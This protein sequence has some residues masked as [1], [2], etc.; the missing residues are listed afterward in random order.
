[1]KDYMTPKQR[2][3]NEWHLIRWLK[4]RKSLKTFA[5]KFMG[6]KESTFLEGGIV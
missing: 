4:S 5:K 6:N 1:M 2:I 3:K